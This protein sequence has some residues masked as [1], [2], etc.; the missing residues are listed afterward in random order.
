MNILGI[1]LERREGDGEGEHERERERT[2]W[3]PAAAEGGGWQRKGRGA[4]AP[5]R[6]LARR[7]RASVGG[8]RVEYVCGSA[9]ARERERGFLPFASP[10][11]QPTTRAPARDTT[12]TA[13]AQTALSLSGFRSSA[14]RGFAPPHRRAR[15]FS[16][17]PILPPCMCN[18]SRRPSFAS[19]A[20]SRTHISA[21]LHP[22]P[23]SLTRRSLLPDPL[24]PLPPL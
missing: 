11:R 18:T 22:P 13:L 21:L 19:R 20:R 12:T 6:T 4:R 7:G 23:T 15:S 16:L 2:R 14:S 10:P 1:R 3:H 8:V 5:L 17:S 24:P 9:S